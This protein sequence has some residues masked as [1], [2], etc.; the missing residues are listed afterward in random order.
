L[1]W[2]ALP[3]IS[4]ASLG[5][6]SACQLPLACT[7]ELGLEFSPRNPTVAVGQSFKAS[8]ELSSCG[9]RE[10][11]RPA[12]VWRTDDTLLVIVE[13][14]TGRVTGRAVGD[15]LVLAV[16]RDVQGNEHAYPYP[17]RVR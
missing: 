4:F 12:V 11:W 2:V 9:G 17:V 5:S 10:R 3:A 15:A 6:V 14:G 7:D 8:L 16:E 13:S 1:R